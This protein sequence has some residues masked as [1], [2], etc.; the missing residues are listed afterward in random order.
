MQ[1]LHLLCCSTS[2]C[3]DLPGRYN[4]VADFSSGCR[5]LR[6]PEHINKFISRISRLKYS[7]SME[8]SSDQLF[9]RTLPDGGYYRDG[10][11]QP[12]IDLQ[13]RRQ[14]IEDLVYEDETTSSM[15]GVEDRLVLTEDPPL[16]LLSRVPVPAPFHAARPSLGPFP[17]MV[18]SQEVHHHYQQIADDPALAALERARRDEQIIAQA[19]ELARVSVKN[20]SMQSAGLALQEELKAARQA[21]EEQ[22]MRV[23]QAEAQLQHYHTQQQ[24]ATDDARKALEVSRQLESQVAE[25]LRRDREGEAAMERKRMAWT[26]SLKVEMSRKEASS[27]TNA[28]WMA[29]FQYALDYHG[30]DYG[31]LETKSKSS[32]V[33][34]DKELDADRCYDKWVYSYWS[35]LERNNMMSFHTK[36]PKAAVKA[37]VEGLR[38]PALKAVIKSHLDLDQKHL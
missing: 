3:R 7:W 2:L 16:R 10:E 9:D 27:V 36:H 32:I 6:E 37:L 8:G 4:L 19:A 5:T 30:P 14:E 26:Q 18:Q 38:P 13:A 28:E 20:E 33:M 29:Y 15:S 22:A 31:D 23:A 17:L 1:P 35:L 21:G 25:L 24:I 11:A 34:D 12:G